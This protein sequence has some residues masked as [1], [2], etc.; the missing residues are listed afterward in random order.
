[1]PVSGP[2]STAA[3]RI[4]WLNNAVQTNEGRFTLVIDGPQIRLH[5]HDAIVGVQ[6]AHVFGSQ[7][8]FA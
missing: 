8:L 7:T 1:M 6:P 3:F 5:H 4:A 2:V